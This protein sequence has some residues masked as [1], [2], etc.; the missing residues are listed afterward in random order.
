M[1]DHDVNFNVPER[2]LK[3]APIEFK[4]KRNKE[5]LGTLF[6]SEGGLEWFPPKKQ[7]GHKMSWK[8]FAELIIPDAVA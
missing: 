7:S 4:I 8:R 1:A 6:V 5:L 3:R 2:E